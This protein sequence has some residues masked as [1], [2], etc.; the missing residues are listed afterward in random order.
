MGFSAEEQCVAIFPYAICFSSI[1]NVVC[2]TTNT[3]DSVIENGSDFYLSLQSDKFLELEEL[4]GQLSVLDTFVTI[5]YNFRSYGILSLSREK[6][7]Q[8]AL[9]SPIIRNITG[10]NCCMQSITFKK[11]FKAF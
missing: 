6:S 7:D 4:P 1:K 9:K 11:R 8:G 3:F 5:S 2:W 10:N